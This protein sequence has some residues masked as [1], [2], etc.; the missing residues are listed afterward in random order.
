MKIGF[1]EATAKGC[2]DLEKDVRLCA[3]AGFDYIEMR[4]DMIR[5]Y[6]KNHNLD[7]LAG[8]LKECG[9][10]PH[11]LNA[12]YT[13]RELFSGNGDCEKEKKFLDEFITVCR[14]A[15]QTGA[16]HLIVVPPMNPAGFL[17]PYDGTREQAEED[18]IRIMRR[19]SEI[20]G[21]YDVKLCLEPVGA[22]KSS[23]RTISEA[24]II[25][26]AVNRANIGI[27][28]DAYNL[29]MAYMDSRYEEIGQLDIDK[30]F[31]VHINNADP[32][33]PS[34]EARRFCDSGIIDLTAFLDELK[35]KGYEGMVS[36][37]TFRPE[38]W[39]KQPEEI[40][41]RA[42]ETTRKTLEDNGCFG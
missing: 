8:L 27:V 14:W 35:A 4:L 1:N 6:L 13:Y 29:Y 2:S 3:Q 23:I 10:R 34:L 37:E 16:C 11:A 7:E 15:Q 18:C 32:V 21:V 31:A 33:E 39:E 20:A 42:Y 28:L 17:V 24:D 36:I 25:I 5:E 41:F 30:I 38:Y 26:K 19:L 12:V 40:I 22:P 9:I